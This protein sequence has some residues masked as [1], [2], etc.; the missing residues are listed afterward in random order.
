LNRSLPDYPLPDTTTG[1]ID[2]TNTAIKTQFL[3]AQYA[4]QKMARDIYLG[5]V[6]AAGAFDPFNSGAPSA[7]QIQALRVLAQQAANIVDYI[8]N[9]DYM[10]PFN[11]GGQVDGSQ[12]RAAGL[13]QIADLPMGIGATG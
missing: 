6:R 9:D 5:L 2:M 4:R 7:E 8:D 3:L 1:R 11:W 13:Q 12:L 10:T